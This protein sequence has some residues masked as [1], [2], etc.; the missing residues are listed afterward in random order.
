MG[1]ERVV[2]RLAGTLETGVDGVAGPSQCSAIA[3]IS[4]G[5]SQL[6]GSQDANIEP[7]LCRRLQLRK[8]RRQ[9]RSG[10]T[11]CRLARLTGL[12]G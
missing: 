11:S 1:R 6:L 2:Q 9:R 3:W 12:K 5:V 4:A 7:S 8:R 10:A